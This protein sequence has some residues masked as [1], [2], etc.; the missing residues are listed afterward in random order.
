MGWFSV[1]ICNITKETI[2]IVIG[3]PTALFG[4]ICPVR[5]D[6]IWFWSDLH[7]CILK[8]WFW[9]DQHN[10]LCVCVCA[11]VRVCACMRACMFHKFTSYVI[12]WEI[13]AFRNFLLPA[14]R[15]LFLL[16]NTLK[17]DSVWEHRERNLLFFPDNVLFKHPKVFLFFIFLFIWC[18]TFWCLSCSQNYFHKASTHCGAS[19]HPLSDYKQS[20]IEYITWTYDVQH[21]VSV[22]NV[23]TMKYIFKSVSDVGLD[24]TY[25]SLTSAVT[26]PAW[27]G[28]RWADTLSPLYKSIIHTSPFPAPKSLVMMS[29]PVWNNRHCVPQEVNFRHSV[30]S[31][32]LGL[33]SATQLWCCYSTW[34]IWMNKHHHSASLLC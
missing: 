14:L 16:I 12:V 6:F 20:Y 26:V 25:W 4:F 34:S 27:S 13:K 15:T 29:H 2:L 28:G 7:I 9:L 17:H 11:C 3:C 10:C 23:P 24:N 19:S 30:C 21:T 18:E 5:F 32:C 33:L 22:D 31:S 1:T 8:G